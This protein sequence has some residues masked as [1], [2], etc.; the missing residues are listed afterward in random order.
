MK[1]EKNGLDPTV[2]IPHKDI[3]GALIC[4][5]ESTRFGSD[6]RFYKIEGKTLFE[7]AFEK[8][9]HLCQ[10]VFCV[11]RQSV[12]PTLQGHQFIFDDLKANGPMAGILSALQA[13]STSYVLILACDVPYISERFLNFLCTHKT[14][15]FE[16]CNGNATTS[17]LTFLTGILELLVYTILIFLEPS[18]LLI[19]AFFAFLIVGLKT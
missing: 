13:S 5:G 6:K 9:T 8:L 3:T 11:F 2:I 15:F 4:G 1:M 18:S 17:V 19:M 12:P 14:N 10:E 16:F 7:S